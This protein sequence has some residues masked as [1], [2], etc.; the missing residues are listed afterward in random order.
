LFDM[1]SDP[2]QTQNCAAAHPGEAARL[3]Q[4]VA[5]WRSEVFGADENARLEKG[6]A[7][8]PRKIGVGYPEFPITM[9][10]ARDGTPRGCVKRSAN[11]PNSS[12][13]VNWTDKT[14]EMA[15]EIEVQTAGAYEVV[16]D[17]TCPPADAGARVEL[18][19][20][21]SRLTGSVS[22]GWDPPLNTNQD[23]LPRPAGESQMKAFHPLALGTVRLE[24][25]TGTLT[26]RALEIP[27]RS[28][29]DVRRVTLTLRP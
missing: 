18:S 4:A 13:F 19:F 29:M 11:A 9:L 23:T 2:G 24:K 12:Y 14:G 21:S 16:I 3:T 22:P 5:A 6:G 26:L 15:W 25:G 17:Y 27:G 10:P 28:V 20:N 7:V 8:D 1:L